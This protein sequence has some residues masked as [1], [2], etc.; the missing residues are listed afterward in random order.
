[1]EL[2][3]SVQH[4][5]WGKSG[6]HSEV[7][8]LSKASNPDYEIVNHKRYAE[9]WMGTHPSGPSMLSKTGEN[10]HEWIQKNQNTLGEKVQEMFGVQLPFLFKVLSVEQALSIQAHPSKAHAEELNKLHPHIYKDANHK[11]E[12]ALALTPFEALC[13]FRP[14]PEIKKYFQIIPE[15]RSCIKENKVKEFFNSSEINEQA[16]LKSCFFELMSSPDH[17]VASSLEK[18]LNRLSS[19]SQE[20]RKEQQAELIER[21]HSQ[22]PGDVG[23]FGPYLFNYLVLNPG[24]A[25]YLGANEPHA[26]LYG[27]CVE[28]M[29]CSDNVVRAGLTPKLKDVPTLCSML[30]YA[31]EPAEQ[32]IFSGLSEDGYTTIFKPPVPDFA[33][34]KIIVPPGSSYEMIKRPSASIVIVISGKSSSKDLTLKRGSILFVPANETLTVNAHEDSETVLMFQAMANIA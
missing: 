13:G 17:Q 5:D 27:D 12:M 1:M 18:L 29:A 16:A 11:P 7:A 15:L 33:V 10:L 8:L 25:I 3:C 28:C 9:L 20:D 24:D 30:T 4:Y 22:F 34:A 26:Y 21:L 31:C 23:I 2:I 14:I 19:L 6:E 32:K